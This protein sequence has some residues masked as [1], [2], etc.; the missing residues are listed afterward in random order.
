MSRDLTIRLG[1]E[2]YG[3][4]NVEHDFGATHV[5]TLKLKE[6]LTVGRCWV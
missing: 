3:E 5:R 2:R 4:R 6:E 1:R